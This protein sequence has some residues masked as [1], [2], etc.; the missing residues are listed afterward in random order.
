M[1]VILFAIF[2][3]AIW[4]LTMVNKELITMADARA[5]EV[6]ENTIKVEKLKQDMLTLE[7]ERKHI[8]QA[9][10]WY[11]TTKDKVV[12]VKQKVTGIF[13]K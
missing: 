8:L 7:S 9:T 6:V 2:A 13:S 4:F 1:K 11:D 3:G 5:A 12:S 10:A